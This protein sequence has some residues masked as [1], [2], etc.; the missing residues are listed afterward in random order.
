[1]MTGEKHSRRDGACRARTAPF[2]YCRRCELRGSSTVLVAS[3]EGSNYNRCCWRE[4]KIELRVSSSAQG[5]RASG[6]HATPP[7]RRSGAA[8]GAADMSYGEPADGLGNLGSLDGLL[9]SPGA[10]PMAPVRAAAALSL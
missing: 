6:P 5:R 3:P 8:D 2:S 10:A 9:G 4:E 1:M 7:Q